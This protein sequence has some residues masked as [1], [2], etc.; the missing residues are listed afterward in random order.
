[1]SDTSTEELFLLGSMLKDN[2]SIEAIAKEVSTEEFSPSLREIYD[3]ICQLWVKEPKKQIT[4]QTVNYYCMTLNPNPDDRHLASAWTQM[5]ERGIKTAENGSNLTIQTACA[6]IHRGR[7]EEA[8]QDLYEKLMKHKDNPFNDVAL[9]ITS[10]INDKV[11][12]GLR[13]P[14]YESLSKQ[15]TEPPTYALTVN[16]RGKTKEIPLS[17]AQVNDPKAVE[18]RI[19]EHF[20]HYPDYRPGPGLWKLLVERLSRKMKLVSV[21]KDRPEQMIPLERVELDEVIQEYLD[22]CGRT[23]DLSSLGPRIIYEDEEHGEI[24]IN[25]RDIQNYARSKGLNPTNNK[26]ADA[27]MKLEFK[28][29]KVGT[30]TG[31]K[32]TRT[33]L[34]VRKEALL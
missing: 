26:L 16:F 34:W 27:L 32:D 10:E 33:K 14:K 21:D 1:M 20:D 24:G 6:R 28:R 31:G 9:A 7:Q 12:N 2:S 15:M 17:S 11:E 25:F 4:T 30:T 22:H 5:C 3:A 29:S 13:L 18:R 19:W 23:S 8:V